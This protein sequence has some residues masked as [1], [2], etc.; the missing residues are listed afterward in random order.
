MVTLASIAQSV[1]GNRLWT[2]KFPGCRACP[3]LTPSCFARIIL[4]LGET[5]EEV[6]LDLGFRFAASLPCDGTNYLTSLGL[7]FLICKI[8]ILVL[9][10]RL[11]WSV[12]AA[13][14]Q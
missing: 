2:L 12:C 5:L 8:G 6:D 1:E 9:V 4:S 11:A 3:D 7:G 13:S 10:S 14:I